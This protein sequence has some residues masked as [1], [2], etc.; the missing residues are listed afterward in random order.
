MLSRPD[1]F[2]KYGKLGVDF[3]STTE[4]LYPN[5]N[6]R[7]RLIRARRD[8]YR[9]SDN[10]NLSLRTVDCSLYAGRIALKDDYHKKRMDMLA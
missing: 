3:S 1:G 5:M 8:F 7:L 6:T 9:I 2:I 4:L 10:L